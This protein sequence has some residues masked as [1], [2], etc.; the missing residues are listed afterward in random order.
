[1]S[2]KN[3]R[4]ICQT[5]E[6]FYTDDF[7]NNAAVSNRA[8]VI[9][10]NT[11]IKNLTFDGNFINNTADNQGDVIYVSGACNITLNGNFINN[12]ADNQGGVIYVSG[13]CNITLNGKFYDNGAVNSPVIA[14]DNADCT[15]INNAEFVNNSLS[16]IGYCY[17]DF[18][19]Y[20]NLNVPKGVA[21]SIKI[22]NINTKTNPNFK[23]S[24]QKI[25]IYVDD[26]FVGEYLFDYGSSEKNRYTY[27]FT[28]DSIGN[29]NLSFVYDGNE[30]LMLSPFNKTVQYN[31]FESSSLK[32]FTDA[33]N[34]INDAES[35]IIKLNGTYLYNSGFSKS[36]IPINRDNL[37]IDGQN[38]TIMDGGQQSAIFNVANN[39]KNL[40]IIN[41]KLTNAYAQNGAINI[42]GPIN[43]FELNA[44]CENNRGY[45]NAGGIVSF[46]QKVEGI[47]KVYGTYSNNR[48]EGNDGVFAFKNT[49]TGN[50]TFNGEFINNTANNGGVAYFANT[51]TGNVTFDGEFINNTANNNGGVVYFAST[52]TGNETFKGKYNNNSAVYHG[53]VVYHNS[54]VK[55]NVLFDG[56]FDSNICTGGGGA[57]AR[58]NKAVNANVTFDGTYSNQKAAGKGGIVSFCDYANGVNT[59]NGTFE[60][61][62]A[63]DGIFKF[64]KDANEILLDGKF[65]D[66]Q[67]SL[68][69]SN[70][71]INKLSCTGDFINNTGNGIAEVDGN[72]NESVFN[73]NFKDNTANILT[74]GGNA[75]NIS[76]T[77]N[78][79]NNDG[80]IA[81]ISGNVTEDISLK[82]DF[83]NNEKVLSIAGDAGDI[84]LAGNFTNNKDGVVECSGDVG[85]VILNGTFSNNTETDGAIIDFQGKMGELTVTGDFSDNVAKTGTFIVNQAD[86]VNVDNASFNNNVADVGAGLTLVDVNNATI[87]NSEFK[88]NSAI[89]GSG[90]II[91]GDNAVIENCNITD[92]YAELSGAGLLSTGNN[93]K[94]SDS[95]FENNTATMGAGF[96]SYGNNSVVENSEFIG[97]DAIK[98]AGIL[99]YGDNLEINGVIFSD[100]VAET[101]AGIVNDADNL[102]IIDSNFTGNTA[103][104][105]A[106][107]ISIDN[108]AKII[109]STFDKNINLNEDG[110]T[111]ILGGKNNTV[112]YS[113]ISNNTGAGININSDNNN[114][115]GIV[116]NGGN[117]TGINVNGNNNGIYNTTGNNHEG[118]LVAAEGNENKVNNTVANGGNGTVVNIINGINNKVNVINSSANHTGDVLKDNGTNTEVSGLSVSDKAFTIPDGIN[119][120]VFSIDLDDESV[121]GGNLTA[122]INGQTKTVP[123]VN[124]KAQITFD[125][126]PAGDYPITVFYTG[127][128]KYSPSGINTTVKIPSKDNIIVAE[129]MIKYYS[130]PDKFAVNVT[131]SDGN[132]LSNK[133]VKFTINGINY[134]RTTDENGSASLNI[135]LLP[136][137]YEILADVDNVTLTRNVTVLSTIN[138]TDIVKIFRN[139]TQYY[140]TIK[141]ADGS[142]LPEGSKV[143]FNINGVLYNRTVKGD[144]GLVKLNI[145]LDEGEYIVTATNLETNE[146]VSNT[147][148]VLSRISSEDITK[149]FKN[150]TQYEVTLLDENG[151]P[152]GAGVSVTFNVNGIFYT[153]Y[154]NDEGVAK[155]NIN[156]PPGDW[157]VTADYDGCLASNNIKVLP[158]LT[159]DNLVKQQG[160]DTPFVATL[161]NG[162]GQP[163]E[164]QKVTFNINGVFDESTTDANGQAK[165]AVNLPNGKY[166]VTSSYNGCSISNNLTITN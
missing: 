49:V 117:G 119:P 5:S 51:V 156:L 20:G 48:V 128:T 14:L 65:K 98:G 50:V 38:L 7:I 52:V 59:F 127:G 21:S 28:P 74:I 44:T 95:K 141:G 18:N 85:D 30:S 60:N 86:K 81:S 89:T 67:A 11:K 108:G 163:Y 75:N 93:L 54:E 154:T 145:N 132:P 146:S 133:T 144:E 124:G 114:V 137:V 123:V 149:Y 88:N 131:D 130:S 45:I 73:G 70:A 27:T 34:E 140:V 166:I 61:N 63:A 4:I 80:D 36:G 77:G 136:G 110:G 40:T 19:I 53:G 25:K 43:Y 112:E 126:L 142:Y 104:T 129:D 62:T 22:Y 135:R 12:T 106:A 138:G 37:I 115:T 87:K 159:A 15:I 121:N 3:M 84:S 24:N 1:M 82:G 134:N 72:V 102:K 2:F 151:N 83:V 122:T 33:L 64:D 143:E 150:D 164:N 101:G 13:A 55:G 32:T 76:F 100:N 94:V 35:N 26:T 91:S 99:S 153:R 116:V 160:T 29:H 6:I 118:T 78:F 157:I 92:N 152:V 23:T 105:G 9:Y 97:N 90:L 79:S 66:N 139:G 107:I 96:I 148:T 147:I 31:V 165:L 17:Y 8:G 71:N 113:L 68:V 109:N 46:A 39:V 47:V 58:F 125:T 111:I 56:I 155:L 103:R 57:V 161:L 158:V 162:Q 42:Q 16:D 120:P 10:V 41:I 69:R